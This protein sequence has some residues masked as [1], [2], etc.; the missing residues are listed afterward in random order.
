MAEELINFDILKNQTTIVRFEETTFESFS[1][2]PIRNTVF[3]PR[4]ITPITVTRSESI[5]LLRKIHESDNPTIAIITQKNNKPTDQIGI[6]DLYKY[7]TMGE[8]LKLVEL[9]S[10]EMSVIVQGKYKFFLEKK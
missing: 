5:N 8:I 7:G 6:K 4:T 2:L 9:K 1:I 10:G 3:F